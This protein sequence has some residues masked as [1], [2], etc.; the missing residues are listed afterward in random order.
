MRLLANGAD[1]AQRI[2]QSERV[3]RLAPHRNYSSPGEG[4]P[5]WSRDICSPA[6]IW[7][8]ALSAATRLATRDGQNQAVTWDCISGRAFYT[9]AGLDAETIQPLGVRLEC[10]QT[11]AVWW[12]PGDTAYSMEVYGRNEPRA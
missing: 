12:M 1:G 10:G 9:N 8:A 6:P 2:A 5:A 4:S 3:A 7:L 11:L